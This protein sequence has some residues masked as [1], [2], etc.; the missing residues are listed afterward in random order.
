MA[1]EVWEEI[2]KY[3]AQGGKMN[4]FFGLKYKSI[5]ASNPKASLG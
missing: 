5:L 4:N 1:K 2:T 3:I